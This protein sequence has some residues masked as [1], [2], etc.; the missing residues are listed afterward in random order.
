MQED[1]STNLYMNPHSDKSTSDCIDQVRNTILN[2]FNT[3]SSKYTVVFTSGTTQSLKLVLESFQF[4]D[5]KALKKC[6]TFMYLQD[7]HTSVLG[8]RELA[9][10]KNANVIYLKTSQFLK[11]LNVKKVVPCW[12]ETFTNKENSLFAYPAQ[13]N[14]NGCKYPIDCCNK[15]KNGCLNRCI[16]KHEGKINNNWYV[17]VDAA[18]FVSTNRLDLFK[19]EP[20][21]VCLSFYKIFGFPTGLGALLIKNESANVLSQK[22]YF[23][24]GTVD[25]VISSEKFHIKRQQLNER[26]F[27]FCF[28]L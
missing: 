3:D 13:S 25:V 16:K 11:A 23:G 14:F 2:H 8:L 15:I 4:N 7:N 21:F 27:L 12:E 1:L 17:L 9:E 24:G 28:K 18:S 22:K 5:G 19:N 6:G 26:Y 10:D 20:D